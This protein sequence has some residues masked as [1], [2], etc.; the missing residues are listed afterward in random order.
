M[1][2][3]RSW[4]SDFHYH[5]I[6][7]IDAHLTYLS[8]QVPSKTAPPPL[9]RRRHQLTLDWVAM[10]I[11]KLFNPLA[12]C[13]NIEIIKPRLPESVRM[14]W[15]APGLAAFARPGSRRHDTPTRTLHTAHNAELQCLN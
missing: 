10:D 13:P 11:A 14:N 3:S 7:I 15:G 9:L 2:R 1:S 8:A 6:H 4:W 5:D 12:F